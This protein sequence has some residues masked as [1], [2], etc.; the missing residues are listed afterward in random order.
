MMASG[1]RVDRET[2]ADCL[3]NAHNRLKASGHRERLDAE[4]LLSHALECPRTYLYAHP[5]LLK[6]MSDLRRQEAMRR[7]EHW[8]LVR[9][10]TGSRPGWLSRQGCWL[11]CQLGRTMVGLGRRLEGYG[12]ARW[13]GATAA[14]WVGAM[15]DRRLRHYLGS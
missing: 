10:A 5:E 9:L 7:A 3:T 15:D 14:R 13:A 6:R 8:R 11:L 2:I 1:I 4:L 12:S